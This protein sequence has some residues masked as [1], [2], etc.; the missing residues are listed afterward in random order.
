MLSGIW[1]AC[2]AKKKIMKDDNKTKKQLVHELTE[3][4][5]Q[6]AELKKSVTVN[7][8]A[9][10]VVEMARRYAESIVETVRE[11]L[12][13][14]DADLKIISASH[15][16]Y[17]TFKVTHNET[18]GSYIYNLGNKQWDIPELRVLL[19]E[20][21][22]KKEAFE[23]FE[24]DHN[25]RN[26]GHKTMLLNA[27]QI[28]QKNIPNKLILLAIEDITERKRVEDSLSTANWRLESIIEGTHVGTWE[29]NVQT[30]ET[31]FNEVWAQIIGYTLAELAPIS[32]QTWETFAHPDDLKQSNELLERHFAGER[33]SYDCTC[34]MK[35][36]DGHWVWVHDRGRVITRTVDGK[37]LMMFGTHTDIT[38]R[39]QV[40]ETLRESEERF[41]R[42][43]NATWEGII[44]HKA[45]I[46]MDTN[47]SAAKMFGCSVEEIIDKSVI[48]FLA[49]ESI[50][51]ALQKLREGITHDQLH[52]EVKALRKDKTVFPAEVLGR[53][54]KYKNTDARVLAFRDITERK[55]TE[56][57]LQDRTAQL[58]AANKE[59]ESFSYSVSHDLRAPLRAIDGYSRII[60]KK[61]GE[62]FDADTRDKFNVIRSNVQ[63]M[64]QLIE[65]LLKFSHLAGLDPSLSKL[66]MA[67]LFHD[68]WHELQTA[69]PDRVMTLK[70]DELPQCTGDRSLMKQVCI[71]ILS[72][73]VKFTRLRE[74]ALIEAG[75]HMEG[76]ECVY[77]VKD[78]GAGFDIAYHDKLFGVFQRLHSDHEY[79]GTGIGLAL[80]KRII[81][82][83]GGRIWAEG[84]VDRGAT[85][86]FTLPTRQ[87]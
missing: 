59:L 22:P 39:K 27:R 3:L 47:E 58:E 80:V 44:I 17:R 21:L 45:G 56:E 11:P 76:N 32:I 67:G 15:N 85:F 71:N 62:Q 57:A 81:N 4:R 5:S 38:F 29:W 7:V 87:E 69:N 1:A 2:T 28:Y 63:M 52:L 51:P 77:F 43:A 25:F 64:N 75:G 84:E 46:I 16:F 50:E 14:L 61:Q 48:D 8:S 68:A 86:Y 23:G 35:H 42:L 78:N 41:N 65:D 13:V 37:P 20:V 54:L 31:I 74:V 19:E 49:P 9:E 24:V 36:K 10:L 82:R 53:P 33:P 18:I 66:D 70:I 12:L 30:G 40:E 26:I 73:A 83:H 79:E 55:Q 60:L 6:N 34:R 72:N